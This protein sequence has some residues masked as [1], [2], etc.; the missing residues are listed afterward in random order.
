MA[1]V[2]VYSVV[3]DS[4]IDY[5]DIISVHGTFKSEAEAVACMQELWRT[6][7]EEVRF[8]DEAFEDSPLML[9]KFED[10]NFVVNHYRLQVIE[11]EM[12]VVD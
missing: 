5:A 8:K 1:K 11:S 10:G 4:V 9:C 3:E 12:E 2:K 7:D 6:N